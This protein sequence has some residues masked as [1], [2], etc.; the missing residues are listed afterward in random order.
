MTDPDEVLQRITPS[1]LRRVMAAGALAA[2]G[3]LLLWITA[4]HPPVDPVFLVMNLVIGGGSLW[5]SGRC[6]GPPAWRW[7]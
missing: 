2:L 5:L 7:T 3:L 6:G 1:T 4:T